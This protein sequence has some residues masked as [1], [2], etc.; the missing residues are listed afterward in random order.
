ENSI[1]ELPEAVLQL[2]RRDPGRVYLHG[3]PLSPR[4]IR[5]LR[6]LLDNQASAVLPV[7][8]HEDSLEDES[9]RYLDGVA[10]SDQGRR[11]AQW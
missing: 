10:P 5:Q 4:A 6:G 7:R 9:L 3:N 1:G 11:L 2:I 8:D